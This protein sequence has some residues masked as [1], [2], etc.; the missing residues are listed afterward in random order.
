MIWATTYHHRVVDEPAPVASHHSRLPVRDAEGADRFEIFVVSAVTSIALTRLYLQLAGWPQLGGGTLHL[1]HLLWGGLLMLIALLLCLLFLG[2]HARNSAAF[3]G[4]VGFGLFID[5]VGKFVTGDNNYFFEPVAAIIYGTFIGL[6][7]LVAFGVQRTPLSSRERVVNA[8]ELL[9][10][11]AAHDMDQGERDRAIALLR[12]ADQSDPMVRPLLL[13]ISGVP[14]QPP[15]RSW[16][17]RFY[18]WLRGVIVGLPKIELVRRLAVLGFVLFPLVS[19]IAPAVQL[20]HERSARSVVYLV[21]ALASLVIAVVGAYLWDRKEF[22]PAFVAFE[23]ALL[24]QLLVV[25]F[26]QLLD[27]QFLGYLPAL[28]NLAM[29]GLCRALS[30]QQSDPGRSRGEPVISVGGDGPEG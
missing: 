12:G 10:E 1:A 8:V 28:F 24:I 15:S 13:A 14:P 18:S 11:S 7:L 29:L 5:E 20:S 26:F 22:G 2:R 27:A 25:Q 16:L 23:V 17:A 3:L 21:F 19:V 4:G 6:Y 30:T 9:K